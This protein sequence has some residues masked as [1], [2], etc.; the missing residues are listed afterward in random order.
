LTNNRAQY[1]ALLLLVLVLGELS[2]LLALLPLDIMVYGWIEHQRGCD[3]SRMLSSEWP[4]VTLVVLVMLLLGYLCY[5]R[6]WAEAGHGTA[7]VVIGGF[8]GELL[9]TVFERARP[10]VIP[11][12]LVGNSFPSGHAAGAVFLAGT[13]SFWLLRQPVSRLAKISG[14]ILLSGLACTVIGQRL[15]LAHHWLSDVIG[16]VLLAV[17]WLCATLSRPVGWSGARPIVAACGA[18]LTS[19]PLFYFVPSL[20]VHLPSALSI[21][22]EPQMSVSF[23]GTGTQTFLQ[24]AWGKNDQEAIGPITWMRR[25]EASV[26]VSL[27]DQH[28]YSM[29]FA[30]R[31]FLQKKDFACFPLEVS[32]NKHLV[33]R[34]LLYRGWREYELHLD[35]AWIVPGINTLTFRTGAD[36][37]SATPNHDA[38][39]FHRVSLFA[40]K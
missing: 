37:P 10:S 21:A 40:K 3:L 7:I 5:Q 33:K 25:G 16:T 14:V 38:I 22:Q 35:P 20:R 24:G 6:R 2:V 26:E 9:K 13:M 36:F 30:A 27:Q 28:G 18:L 23:G 11:P 39:A 32:L 15:Y 34:M 4:L 31:P 1:L 8:L 12:L 29:R 17:A 19:Y